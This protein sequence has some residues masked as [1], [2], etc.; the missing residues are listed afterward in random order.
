MILTW[1][2]ERDVLLTA[3]LVEKCCSTLKSLEVACHSTSTFVWRLRP[4]Q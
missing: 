1:N 4:H 2:D 3:A